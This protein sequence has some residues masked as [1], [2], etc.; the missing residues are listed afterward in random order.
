MGSLQGHYFFGLEVSGDSESLTSL[1]ICAPTPSMFEDDAESCSGDHPNEC[2]SSWPE[3]DVKDV[4]DG[5]RN[6]S[7]GLQVP[8]G[9]IDE[10]GTAEGETMDDAARKSSYATYDLN[11]WEMERN[12][13]FWE[14]CLA[15]GLSYP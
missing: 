3:E 15:S 5:E 10:V 9:E 8:E 6:T 1:V 13:S 11:K 14:T 7:F 4:G 12:R 2:L